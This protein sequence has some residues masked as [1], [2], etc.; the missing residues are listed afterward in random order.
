MKPSRTAPHKSSTS[1]S[2]SKTKSF[3]LLGGPQS[4]QLCI[5]FFYNLMNALA[6]EVKRICNLTQ[7]HSLVAHLDD[8]QISGIIGSRAR[9]QGAPLPAVNR[10]QTLSAGLW[11]HSL[12]AALTGVPNPCTYV[13]FSSVDDFNVNCRDSGVTF[14]RGELFDG[15]CIKFKTCSVIHGVNF[16][17]RKICMREQTAIF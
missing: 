2:S 10:I 11:Q 4:S 5:E 7:R 3:S 16:I 9:L 13:H 12:F 15:S 17:T 14:A 8:V 1:S 6:A